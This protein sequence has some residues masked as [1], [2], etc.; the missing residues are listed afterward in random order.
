VNRS[1]TQIHLQKSRP[2]PD[3]YLSILI[4]TKRWLSVQQAKEVRESVSFTDPNGLVLVECA[5][6]WRLVDR[7][8]MASDALD[9]FTAVNAHPGLKEKFHDPW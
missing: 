4:E 7:W 3:E 1:T 8:N 5:L 2:G 9:V 6:L